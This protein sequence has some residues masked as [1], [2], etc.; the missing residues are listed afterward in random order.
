MLGYYSSLKICKAGLVF[1]VDIA[2]SCFLTGGPM[3]DLVV[4][5]TNHRSVQELLDVSQEFFRKEED[6]LARGKGGEDGK[7]YGL[8]NQMLRHI[9]AAYKSCKIKLTHVGQTRKFRSFGRHDIR[10]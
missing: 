6:V 2:V 10:S 5:M 3:I 9:E 7:N 4:G 1:V 8:P